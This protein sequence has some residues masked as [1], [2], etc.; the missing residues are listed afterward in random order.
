MES[1]GRWFGILHDMGLHNDRI[2]LEP[3]RLKEWQIPR[4]GHTAVVGGG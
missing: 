1:I 2:C 4:D 3:R